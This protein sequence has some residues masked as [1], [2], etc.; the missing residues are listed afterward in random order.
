[1]PVNRFDQWSVVLAQSVHRRLVIDLNATDRGRKLA[2][3][4]MLRGLDCPGILVE[5][6]F[7]TSAAEAKKIATAAYRQRIAEALAAGIRDY[8]ATVE[9]TRPKASAAATSS[10]SAPP[11]PSS[12]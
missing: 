2:H 7:L 11:R 4:G 5:C 9:R 1:M 12:S 8:V 3:W 6:G 10:A